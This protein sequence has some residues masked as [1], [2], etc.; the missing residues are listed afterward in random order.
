MS[1]KND[2]NQM[3]IDYR[4]LFANEIESIMQ[5]INAVDA[6][7]LRSQMEVDKL[8]KKNTL[9]SSNIEKI[10]TIVDRASKDQIIQVYQNG[11]DV[12]QRFMTM[13]SQV[14]RL[15]IEKT[16]LESEIVLLE[17][18]RS[19][20]DNLAG[21]IESFAI[22]NSSTLETIIQSQE[23]ERLNL[24]RQMHDG[25]A[26]Q[27]SNFILQT[28]IAIRYFSLDQKKAEEELQALKKTATRIFED[29][30]DFIFKLRPM[31]LDDLGLL[32]TMKR[33]VGMLDEKTDPKISLNF[34]GND[35]RY[36]TYIEIMIFRAIQELLD[37]AIKHGN[38]TVI[39]LGLDLSDSKITIIVEDD[40]TGFEFATLGEQEGVGIMALQDRVRMMSGEIE[41]NSKINEG[42]VIS[43]YIPTEQ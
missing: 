19:S 28:E 18:F 21:N 17:K 11:L 2:K 35:R 8:S 12:N 3:T 14:D 22:N 37:N 23:T 26:Q 9:A 7:I 27:M 15:G 10:Q 30:R 31:M 6:K 42:T 24:A 32:P 1:P 20:F 43:F 36:K 38:A 16:I 25:P 29:I 34:T 4:A 13:R 5:K 40:G 33:F 39:K 41:I